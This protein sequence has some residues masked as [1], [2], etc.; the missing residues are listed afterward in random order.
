MSQSTGD[1][2]FDLEIERSLCQLRRARRAVKEVLEVTMA[3]ENE[4]DDKAMK[5]YL[6]PTLEGYSSS[7]V[8]LLVQAK[9]EDITHSVR[10]TK[11]PICWT[12]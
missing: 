6:A 11:L 3:N 8:R 1:L 10:A 4:H 5:D 9:A 7:I 2:L 12:T